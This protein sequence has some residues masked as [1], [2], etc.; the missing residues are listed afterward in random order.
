[1][2]EK[3]SMLKKIVHISSENILLDLKLTSELIGR[4]DYHDE[5]NSFLFKLKWKVRFLS[6]RSE[7]AQKFVKFLDESL[8]MIYMAILTLFFNLIWKKLIIWHKYLNENVVLRELNTPFHCKL[9]RF[10]ISRFECIW[11]KDLRKVH[12]RPSV[13]IHALFGCKN[14][15]NRSLCLS[16][17]QYRY[18]M[19]IFYYLLR[20]V[21]FMR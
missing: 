3:S 19:K 5:S 13:D 17:S 2:T 6:R 18:R 11:K 20:L 12:A 9:F 4:S 14:S 8:I 21:K 10:V 1:M 7:Q 16:L 15:K